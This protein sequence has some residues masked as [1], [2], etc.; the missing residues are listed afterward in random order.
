MIGDVPPVRVPL[1]VRP[2]LDEQALVFQSVSVATNLTADETRIVANSLSL[3]RR[4]VDRT[5]GWYHLTCDGLSWVPRPGLSESL[6]QAQLDQPHVDRYSR[7]T[8]T[9]RT[10]TTVFN[11]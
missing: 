6:L 8:V 11:P 10:G 2:K 5:C 1:P 9:Y 4:A 7:T 3:A